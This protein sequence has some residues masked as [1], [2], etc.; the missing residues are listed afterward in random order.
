ML[1]HLKTILILVL[2]FT[3]FNKPVD[4][5]NV[6]GIV[7]AMI[8]YDLVQIVA[9]L[10]YNMLYSRVIAYTEIRRRQANPTLPTTS[11]ASNFQR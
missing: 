8:G 7:V 3:T 2:G 6:L 5:R 9:F 4:M 11:S 1:G 10:L